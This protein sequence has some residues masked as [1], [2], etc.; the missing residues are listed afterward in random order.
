MEWDLE[1]GLSGPRTRF[2]ALALHCPHHGASAYLAHVID[3]YTHTHTHARSHAQTHACTHTQTHRHTHALSYTDTDRQTHT[4]THLVPASSRLS[5][6]DILL[7]AF[8]V[9][10][11][12]SL[13]RTHAR[14]PSQTTALRTRPLWDSHA[15]GLG[16]GHVSVCTVMRSS[17]VSPPRQTVRLEG[18]DGAWQPGHLSELWRTHIHC[19]SHAQSQTPD[20]AGHALCP[21]GR[22][23]TLRPRRGLRALPLHPSPPASTCSLHPISMETPAL[24][25]KCLFY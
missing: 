9:E 23:Y 8:L 25:P 21:E 13:S 17:P 3:C 4:H 16:Q 1:A 5:A 19:S 6:P 10:G 12:V 7:T 15:R 20:R 18:G 24:Q 11:R 2:L 22:P 14:K